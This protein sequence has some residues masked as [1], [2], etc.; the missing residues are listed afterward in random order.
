MFHRHNPSGI[1]LSLR[2]GWTCGLPSMHFY[3]FFRF[4]WNSYFIMPML[5]SS[6]ED[7]ILS[8]QFRY[9]SFLDFIHLSFTL[10]LTPSSIIDLSTICSLSSNL[11][12]FPRR[13]HHIMDIMNNDLD[14][15]WVS[16]LSCLV[17]G[18]SMCD[19][20]FFTIWLFFLTSFEKGEGVLL[21][22]PGYDHYHLLSLVP[23][24][25]TSQ[26]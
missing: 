26:G 17:I 23:G 9:F 24:P 21:H 10:T 8:T 13:K 16:W 7:T 4:F 2:F 12:P 15:F 6:W 18:T 3:L 20:F 19:F 25:L 11:T 1:L 22:D 5:L 14:L